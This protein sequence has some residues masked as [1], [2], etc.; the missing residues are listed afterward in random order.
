VFSTFSFLFSL[1]TS[2]E[3]CNVI[4]VEDVKQRQWVHLRSFASVH[5]PL[6]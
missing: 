1:S 3:V 5:K 2:G 4:H 6:S